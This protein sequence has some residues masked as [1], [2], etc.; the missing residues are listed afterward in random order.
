[1]KK[2]PKAI[3]LSDETENKIRHDLFV[4]HR[5]P[6]VVAAEYGIGIP[7]LRRICCGTV[8]GLDKRRKA[9]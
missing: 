6:Y 9:A 5:D 2:H 3:L 8:P 7:R 1:M 4:E